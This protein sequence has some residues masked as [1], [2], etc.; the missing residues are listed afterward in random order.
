MNIASKP[1]IL[2]SG[3][4]NKDKKLNE[5]LMNL[6]KNSIVNSLNKILKIIGSPKAMNKKAKTI[7]QNIST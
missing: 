6:G 1:A 7:V 2:K 5:D 4:T 3:L